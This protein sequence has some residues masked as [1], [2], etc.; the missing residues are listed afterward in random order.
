MFKLVIRTGNAAFDDN[1]GPEVARILR[2]ASR[3][4]DSGQTTGTLRDVNGNVVGSF[5]LKG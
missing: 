2:D 3:A 5:E 4:V 1:A